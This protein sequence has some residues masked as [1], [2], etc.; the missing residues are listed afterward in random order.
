[1]GN[2]EI[3]QFEVR[4][5]CAET[6]FLDIASPIVDTAIEQ[7]KGIGSDPTAEELHQLR[8]TMRRL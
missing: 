7:A 4:E 5:P 1:M 2:G 6:A 3:G 8:I